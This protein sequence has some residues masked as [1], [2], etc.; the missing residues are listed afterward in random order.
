[1]LDQTQAAASMARRISI[2]GASTPREAGSGRGAGFESVAERK[3]HRRQLT[4]DCNVKIG[5]RGFRE[6]YGSRTAPRP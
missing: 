2:L 3:L 6:G 5:G 4:E 1:V